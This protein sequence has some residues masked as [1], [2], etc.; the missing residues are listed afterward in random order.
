[1]AVD[2][3]SFRN[4]ILQAAGDGIVSGLDNLY[5]KPELIIMKFLQANCKV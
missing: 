3:V 5:L 4:F 1:M 2:N